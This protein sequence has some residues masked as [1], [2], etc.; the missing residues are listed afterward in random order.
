MSTLAG[1]NPVTFIA[2][3]DREAAKTFY[4]ATLGFPLVHE[5]LYA[6]VFDLNGIML[7][8]TPLPEFTPQPFTVLGWHVDDVVTVV[9][10]L[11]DAGIV[12]ERFTGLQQDDFGVWSPGGDVKVAWFRDPD[13]NILSVSNG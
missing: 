9:R 5:D 1:K 6:M 10:M 7:R 11:T 13:R 4:G 3:R 2:T 8:V 12:F